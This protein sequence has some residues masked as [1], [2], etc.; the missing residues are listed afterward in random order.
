MVTFP[1]GWKGTWKIHSF[2]KKRIAF[3]DSKGLRVDEDTDDEKET[4]NL[5]RR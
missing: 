2:L 3:F 1:K 5:K 4:K